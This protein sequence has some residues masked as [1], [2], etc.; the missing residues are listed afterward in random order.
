MAGAGAMW[1]E[2]VLW[3]CCLTRC[4]WR[5]QVL[6]RIGAGDMVAPGA[7]AALLAVEKLRQMGLR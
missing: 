7:V 4:V 6:R 5:E 3:N 2:Q 1:R